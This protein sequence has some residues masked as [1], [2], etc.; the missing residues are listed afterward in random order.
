M[1]GDVVV[2][3]AAAA[4]QVKSNVILGYTERIGQL[5]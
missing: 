4:G 5:A 1:A 3:A 2:G